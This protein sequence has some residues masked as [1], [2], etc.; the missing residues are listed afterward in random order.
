MFYLYEYRSSGK[1]EF[2]KD[3]EHYL[4]KKLEEYLDKPPPKAAPESEPATPPTSDGADQKSASKSAK[5]SAAAATSASAKAE[6]TAPNDV[7]GKDG[8]EEP[9]APAPDEESGARRQLSVEER[10]QVEEWFKWMKTVLSARRMVTLYSLHSEAGID[11]S[12]LEAVFKSRTS[13]LHRQ[14]ELAIRFNRLDMA[15]KYVLVENKVKDKDKDKDSR[16]HVGALTWRDLLR[17]K[18]R[19]PIGTVSRHGVQMLSDDDPLNRSRKVPTAPCGCL[20]CDAAAVRVLLLR[21]C[22]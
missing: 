15:H 7:K 2:S 12:I 10:R 1:S 6:D 13:S 21:L 18:P 9:P 16:P 20:I 14:L 8:G 11:G 19:S 3:L 4:L 22:V 5:E 17:L